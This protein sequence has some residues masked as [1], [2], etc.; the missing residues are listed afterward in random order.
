[1]LWEM[2]W[3]PPWSHKE[4]IIFCVIVMHWSKR[5]MREIPW[6]MQDIWIFYI[7][8]QQWRRRVLIAAIVR[9][10]LLLLLRLLLVTEILNIIEQWN[11]IEIVSAVRSA[12]W[13][14]IESVAVVVIAIQGVSS[15]S[16]GAIHECV[17]EIFIGRENC[18]FVLEGVHDLARLH[19]VRVILNI[20]IV[21]PNHHHSFAHVV[22]VITHILH[23]VS[24][25]CCC[26]WFRCR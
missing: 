13:K 2:K 4:P 21:V 23:A 26:Y 11:P 18:R 5:T 7:T 17:H 3:I 15:I 12:K 10:S 25:C 22:V 8:R 1:M 9:I 24:Y 14:K 20:I 19:E 6:R 16:M